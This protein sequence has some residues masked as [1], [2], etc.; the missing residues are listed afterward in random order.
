MLRRDNIYV[1]TAGANPASAPKHRAYNHALTP[2]YFHRYSK[3]SSIVKE[4][5]ESKPI[6]AMFNPNNTDL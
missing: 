4:I 5:G 6:G 3:E 1:N 2:E